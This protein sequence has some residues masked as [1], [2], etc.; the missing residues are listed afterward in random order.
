MNFHNVC[1]GQK[2]LAGNNKVQIQHANVQWFEVS[3]FFFF[4]EIFHIITVLL[5]F[6]IK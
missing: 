4:I 1:E 5:Y 2:H 3:K 6:L